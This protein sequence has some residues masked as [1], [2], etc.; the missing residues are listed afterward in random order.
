MQV[1]QNGG[2]PHVVCLLRT[3]HDDY[4]AAPEGE[5]SGRRMRGREKRKATFPT[6]KQNSSTVTLRMPSSLGTD[7]F[8]CEHFPWV[9]CR[10]CPSAFNRTATR[11]PVARVISPLGRVICPRATRYGKS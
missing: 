6:M 10:S 3:Q 9:F 7:L 11:L 5:G 1:V 2:F 8:P 4:T